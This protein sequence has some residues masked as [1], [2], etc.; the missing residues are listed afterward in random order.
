MH[1][2]LTPGQC[3]TRDGY[4]VTSY[5]IANSDQCDVIAHTRGKASDVIAVPRNIRNLPLA[6]GTA[7][8]NVDCEVH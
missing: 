1:C 7:P 5:S 6:T 4:I 3:C 8:Q 2:A